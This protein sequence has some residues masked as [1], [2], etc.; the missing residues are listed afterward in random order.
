MG[1]GSHARMRVEKRKKVRSEKRQKYKTKVHEKS[2]RNG[3]F[4]HV[5]GKIRQISE[6]P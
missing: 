3:S 1:E 4:F 6:F 5:P 2:F